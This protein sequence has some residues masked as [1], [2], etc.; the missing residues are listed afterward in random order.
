MHVKQLFFSVNLRAQPY[1]T[2]LE[3]SIA[4]IMSVSCVCYHR[5]LSTLSQLANPQQLHR[6]RSAHTPLDNRNCLHCID[7][8]FSRLLFSL[9]SYS[10]GPF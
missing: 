5:R 9:N 7:Y 10:G 1:D 4:R 2:Y 8:H 6:F 3:I